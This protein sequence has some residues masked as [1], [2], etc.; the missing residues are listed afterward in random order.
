MRRYELTIDG[1]GGLEL[2]TGIR[3]ALGIEKGGWVT[4][5]LDGDV[6][7]IGSAGTRYVA[8]GERTGRGGPDDR[9]KGELES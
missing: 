2:P 6:L 8:A 7:R 5:E 1:D 3:Q 4:L 9:V